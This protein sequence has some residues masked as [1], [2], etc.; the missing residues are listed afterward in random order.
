VSAAGPLIVEENLNEAPPFTYDDE[1]ILFLSEL[2]NKT[3]S[4]VENELL[5]PLSV[6]QWL[7]ATHAIDW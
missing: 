5:K 2:F 1:R 6:V 7:V 4:M 3:D